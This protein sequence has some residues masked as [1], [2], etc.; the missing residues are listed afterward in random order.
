[1]VEPEFLEEQCRSTIMIRLERFHLEIGPSAVKGVPGRATDCAIDKQSPVH[2]LSADNLIFAVADWQK[3][4]K[5][6]P[7][8]VVPAVAF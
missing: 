8:K 1:V 7:E 5:A 4:F 3:I 6:Q 2:Y